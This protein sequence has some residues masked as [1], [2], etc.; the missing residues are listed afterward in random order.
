MGLK[1]VSKKLNLKIDADKKLGEG[2][3]GSVFKGKY[4]KEE[5]AIK[6]VQVIDNKDSSRE[7]E[8]LQKLNHE[9][10][11][12]LH[13]C[14][15]NNNFRYETHEQVYV[16]VFT[17]FLLIDFSFLSCVLQTYTHFAKGNTPVQYPPISKYFSS[18]LKG[19]TISIHSV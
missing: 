8:A 19:W 11:V 13:L 6:R 16:F 10:V 14:F 17:F 15:T 3:Y 12:K 9:N 18:W 5:V 2:S 1:F 4:N 7:E